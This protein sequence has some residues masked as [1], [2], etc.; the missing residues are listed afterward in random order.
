MRI[1]SVRKTKYIYIEN[2][3]QENAQPHSPNF[4]IRNQLFLL[5]LRIIPISAQSKSDKMTQ[6]SVGHVDFR[7]LEEVTEYTVFVRR[8]DFGSTIHI[9]QTEIFL[10]PLKTTDIHVVYHTRRANKCG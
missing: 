6:T 8:S 9:H 5:T 4:R 7:E 2:G 1:N 3:F 10:R